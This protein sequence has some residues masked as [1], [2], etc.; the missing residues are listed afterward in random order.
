MTD[1]TQIRERIAAAKADSAEPADPV[2][3]LETYEEIRDRF[4]GRESTDIARRMFGN[5]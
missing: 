4:E 5:H 2:Q 1:W 3:P